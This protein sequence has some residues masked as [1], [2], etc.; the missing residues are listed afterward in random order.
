[1]VRAAIQLCVMRALFAEE[2]EALR[3]RALDRHLR[4]ISSG[5]GPEVK[6]GGRRFINFSS[7]DYLG[8]A[9]DPQLRKA[10]TAAIDEFGVG[11]GASRLITGTLSPHLRLEHALAK[12]KGTEATLCFSSGYAAALGTIPALV[13]KDD[14]VVLDK[15]CH[16]SLIDGAKLS[17]ATLRVF[18]HN[19]V[20]KLESHLEWARREHAGKRVL[21][22]TESVFSMDGDRAPLRELIE[23][24]KQFGALLM[25]D[26]AHAVGVIGSNGCGLAAA[27][28]LSG[29]IDVQ[30]GTLSKALGASGAYICGSA[31]LIEWLINRARSFI[32]STAPPP[33]IAAAALAAVDFLTSPEG[34]ERRLLLRERIRLMQELLPRSELSEEQSAA[35]SAIFPWI[36]G[37]EKGA[38]DLAAALQTEGFLVPAIRYPT[39]AKRAA[40]L[41]ITV[42]ASHEEAQ[43]RAL[44]EAIKRLGR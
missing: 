43:I 44:C 21:I 26:E 24:K 42:T 12:W 33:A 5:Q 38:L 29:E 4:E 17:G 6:I 25:L 2:L 34:E 20:G 3:K 31:T 36:V 30:M 32:Y 18:P 7:N 10:A 22:I 19:H 13:G 40:R 28:D 11:A 39:V 9:N 35:R 15:L 27:E 8:L 16:A 1:L 37:D 14:V 23:L 41:R